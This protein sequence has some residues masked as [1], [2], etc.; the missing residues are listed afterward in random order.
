M[1]QKLKTARKKTGMKQRETSIAI[2]VSERMYRAI[3]NGKREGKGYIWDAL[4]ALFKTPQRELRENTAHTNS[5]TDKEAVEAL[6]NPVVAADLSEVCPALLP[7]R[8][9]APGREGRHGRGRG[10]GSRHK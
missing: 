2:G 1:R 10:G 6:E 4:E 9:R 3:E 8:N 7:G 5:N